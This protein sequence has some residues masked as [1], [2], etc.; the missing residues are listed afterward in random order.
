MLQ[1]SEL[2]SGYGS[3]EVL[4]G[5]TFEV[6][7]GAVTAVLGTNGAGKTTLMRTL[8]GL[9]HARTGTVMFDGRDITHWHESDRAR[10]GLCLI[11]EGRGIFRQLSV[12]DNVAM[13]VRGRNSARSFERAAS[14]FPK[15]GERRSQLAGTLSGGEQ[16]MLAVSRALVTGPKLVMVDELSLGLAPV[17]IDEIFAA[18][19]VLREDGASLLLI[20]QY[21]DRILDVAE[22]IFFLRKGELGFVG[23]PDDVRQPEVLDRLH[24]G[25]PL[26]SNR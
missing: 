26:G 3:I 18:L 5:L 20:D 1:I 4:H 7:P 2:R 16:Q 11:P 23:Q 9:V 17:V 15:L 6:P 24:L 12:Y 14:V 8:A 22:R 19:E 25:L 10:A 21:V 13:F